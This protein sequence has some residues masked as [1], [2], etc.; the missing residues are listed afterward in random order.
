MNPLP[1]KIAIKVFLNTLKEAQEITVLF[2]YFQN[3]LIAIFL[4]IGFQSAYEW[5]NP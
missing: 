2:A 1:V 3:I 4:E 5:W